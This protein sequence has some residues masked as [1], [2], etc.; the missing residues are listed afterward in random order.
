MGLISNCSLFARLGLLLA[1]THR[2]ENSAQELLGELFV[3]TEQAP[4]SPH[5]IDISVLPG[6]DSEPCRQSSEWSTTV[7]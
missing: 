1:A 4:D 2:E 7:V 3:Q 5:E 6:K